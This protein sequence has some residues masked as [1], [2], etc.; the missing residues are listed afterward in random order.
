MRL[1]TYDLETPASV[2]AGEAQR[3]DH[4][5]EKTF[6]VGGTFSATMRLQGSLDGSSWADIS[7]DITAPSAL[8]FSHSVMYVRVNVTA[9][10]SGAP[11]GSI[12][13]ILCREG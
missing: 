1:E 8:A 5:V 10:V 6:L 3:V 11:A 12:C 13:G 9:Y 4:L 7:G 2:A